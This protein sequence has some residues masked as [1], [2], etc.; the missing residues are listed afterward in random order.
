MPG[1][2]AHR[3]GMFLG[4]LKRR[5]RAVRTAALAAASVL[6]VLAGC[7]PNPDTSTKPN[8]SGATSGQSPA[9][10]DGCPISAKALSDATSQSWELSERRE[11]HPLETSE[12]TKATICLFTTTTFRD[13]YGDPLSFR[14]DVVTGADAATVRRQFA[15]TCLENGGV[16]RQSAGGSVCERDAAV[17]E[18]IKGDGDRVV[19]AYFVNAHKAMAPALTSAFPKILAAVV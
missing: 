7:G 15:D 4:M 6:V 3:D 12:S 17:L 18:G 14:S 11:N 9:S 2:G 1:Q 19:N 13:Q 16:T 8:A 10:P 5:P